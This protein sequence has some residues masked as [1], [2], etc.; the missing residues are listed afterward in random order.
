MFFPVTKARE[1]RGGGAYEQRAPLIPQVL[2]VAAAAK[3][4]ATMTAENFILTVW[5]GCLVGFG[6]GNRRCGMEVMVVDSLG[7]K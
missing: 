4:K 6:I 1:C 2:A 3:V 5:V 7:V